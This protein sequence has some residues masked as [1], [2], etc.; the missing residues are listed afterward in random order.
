[1]KFEAVFLLVVL[2]VSLVVFFPIFGVATTSSKQFKS[3]KRRRILLARFSIVV[4]L[5]ATWATLV[6]PIAGMNSLIQGI[7]LSAVVLVPVFLLNL[8]AS[9]YYRSVDSKDKTTTESENSTSLQSD[10]RPPTHGY[11]I[12]QQ[13]PSK[14]NL[15]S[16]TESER[17]EIKPVQVETSAQLGSQYSSEPKW[18]DNFGA[19][20]SA[21]SAETQSVVS[22]RKPVTSTP[23]LSEIP[24]P[25]IEAN[26][27]AE[28]TVE[29]QLDRVSDFVQSHDLDIQN[30]VSL[31]ETVDSAIRAKESASSGKPQLN[32][33]AS[34]NDR[35]GELATMGRSEMSELVIS[36]RKGNG[37]LQKL[38]IAQHAVIESERASHNRSRDV[39]RQAIKIMRD[40]QTS[41][42][43]AE[44]MS[45][46]DKTERQR[47]QEKYQ[48]VTSVLENAMSII[49]DNTDTARI[50]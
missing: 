11:R 34:L 1:M 48:K 21:I 15:L 33:I 46:R 9:L 30:K 41:Q 42:K 7:L 36:L 47:I 14:V 32:A 6:S 26:L 8:L 5:L 40:A 37:R 3:R 2:A 24:K 10:K 50:P 27:P 18:S 23:V 29:E 17:I 4:L 22:T 45:R 28:P 16:T 31:D 35:A 38:V 39:A 49:S 44:K 43:M 13:K 12:E 19:N 20:E 25:F